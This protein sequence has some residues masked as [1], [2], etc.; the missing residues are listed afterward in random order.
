MR[1]APQMRLFATISLIKLIVSGES[2]GLLEIDLDLCFQNTRKSP[3]CQREPRLWLDNEEGLFPGSKH[4]CKKQ[5]EE[6]VCLPAGWPF[7]L[8]TQDNKLLS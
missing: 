5:Q 1:S 3:R 2:F 8:S 6:S 7:D 4:P